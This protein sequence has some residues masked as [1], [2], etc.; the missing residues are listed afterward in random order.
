[1]STK[2]PAGVSEFTARSIV[3]KQLK[4]WCEAGD[5][6]KRE[7]KKILSVIAQELANNNSPSKT[8]KLAKNLLNKFLDNKEIRGKIIEPNNRHLIFNL[9]FIELIDNE[10]F[11][12][13]IDSEINARTGATQLQATNILKINNHVIQRLLERSSSRTDMI[14][15]D[16]IYSAIDF[17]KKWCLAAK[18]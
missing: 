9:S 12:S 17:T 18:M 5:K 14:A 4:I 3:S 10:I 15:L 13:V 2:L 11:Y 1:M 8:I 7:L 16:E 6:N